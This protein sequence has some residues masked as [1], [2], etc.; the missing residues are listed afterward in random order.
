[1]PWQFSL[2]SDI[3]GRSEQ[4][5]CLDM[6]SSESGD[7]HLVVVAIVCVVLAVI[8]F[9]HMTMWPAGL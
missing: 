2:A 6:L 9:P 3:G 4:Q 1:M 5:D 8:F 7:T